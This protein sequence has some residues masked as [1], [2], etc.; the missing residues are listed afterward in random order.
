VLSSFQPLL[1]DS[2]SRPIRWSHL[3]G[4]G[5]SLA[6]AKASQQHQGL[7]CVAL[8]DARQV[9]IMAEELGFFLSQ[10]D[11]NTETGVHIF[12][13][14]ETLAYDIFSPHQDIISSRLKLLSALPDFKHGILLTTTESLLQRLPPIDYVLAHSFTLKSGSTVQIEKLRLQLQDVGYY[15][16]NQVLSQ[17]EF[18][19]RGGLIDIFPMGTTRPFRL[20]LFDDEIE[21]I[22]YFDPETQ[23][24]TN[25]TNSINLLP[26]REVP[27][28]ETGIKHFRR[29]F[30][31]HFEGDPSK[32]HVYEE[33]SQGRT[34]PGIEFYL[35]LFFDDTATLFDYLP[36]SSLLVLEGDHQDT[37]ST[38][39]AQI[40]DRYEARKDDRARKILPPAALYLDQTQYTASLENFS[41]I[42]HFGST[43]KNTDWKAPSKPPKEYPVELRADKPYLELSEHLHRAKHRILLAV[44]TAGRREALEG[45]LIEHNLI[46]EP[47]Q[48]WSTFIQ[49]EDKLGIIVGDIVRGLIV[50]DPHIELITE[51]Q[52]YGEK[53]LQRRQRSQRTA[54]DP[55]AIIRS[56]AELQIGAPVVHIDHG[57]GR[58]QGLQ[59]LSMNDLSEEFLVI[60]YHGADKLY[61]PIQ[62][63]QMISRFVGGD[64]ELAPLHKLGSQ[65]W[66]KAKKKAQVKS[67]DVAVELLEMQAARDARTGVSFDIPQKDYHLF[68]DRFGFE[69][70]HDQMRAIND[71]IADLKSSAPMDRLVC[72]DVGFGKTEVA[73]RAAFVAAFNGK[74]VIML[75]PTTLL[76]QQH[77][78]TFQN[79][80]ADMPITIG[81]LSRFSS[82]KETKAVLSQMKEGTSDIIIGT[83]RLIQDDIRL[84]NLGLIIIDEEHRFGVRQKEKLKRLRNEVDILTLTATPI[85]RTLNMTMSGLREISIIATPP[86]QRLA[87][88]TFVMDY[89]QAIIR[90]ACLREI[91]RGGQ[92]YFLHNEVKTIQ[93]VAEELAELLPEAKIAFAHGQMGELQLEQIMRDFYHQKFNILVAT[94][95]IE[96]GIDV[97]SA[98]TIII[99]R[100]DKFGLA[101]LHQLRGRVGRSHHQAFAYLLVPNR[102]HVSKDAGKRLAAIEQLNDLGAGFSL[103]SHDLEI[104]GAGELLGETQ[105]GLIDDVGFNLYTDYLNR[106][107][108]AIKSAGDKGARAELNLDAKPHAAV[109]MGVA[110]LFPD[111]YLN[112]I[113]L[114]LVMYK[115][116]AGAQT[117]DEL[118]ELEVESIDRFGLLPDAGKYLFRCTALKLKCMPLGISKIDVDDEGG[119]IEFIQNAAIDPISI[120]ELVQAQPR[121]FSLQ[122]PT[123]L[124]ISKDLEE[125]AARFGFVDKIIDY[126]SSNTI[127]TSNR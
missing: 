42:A 74:Q 94:T 118:K 75:V 77:F 50:S 124:K 69:E 16:V 80:F 3:F 59:V 89:N 70:T 5:L 15:H 96:S 99:N 71:V 100:A 10:H 31:E 45:V 121:V 20:D 26:A 72:G 98:N 30:R 106:A 38:I 43:K 46:P 48:D 8:S 107:I 35:P 23:K 126:F 65:S 13:E 54:Q 67:Y 58:Y 19:I 1:P 83:H 12:P 111:N 6:I 103:A 125:E 29:A 22:R 24:S 119:K 44:E 25:T 51:G 14:W 82:Q 85:P 2:N 66:D 109:S 86:E 92:M 60:T 53:V 62:S 7:L 93:R 11:T 64:P 18:A 55:E 104:R 84:K 110:A 97:P 9:Q 115:R 4:A 52:L 56:L 117:S 39:I 88:K 76:A 68:S 108:A 41:L 127:P 91:H 34:T 61:V 79:R 123:I 112:N 37:V 21:S 95:I 101:Q 81:L 63:L 49:S 122:G 90:E 17:G 113:H 116:I 28:T 47:Q 78:E 114:R 120:I 57:V 73:L 87:I 36:S 40:K 33:V 32:Q 102:K 105:S 27:L